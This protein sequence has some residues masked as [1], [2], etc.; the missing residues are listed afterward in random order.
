[1]AMA[2]QLADLAQRSALAQHLGSQSMTKL[3]SP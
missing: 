2:E 3:V 1:M